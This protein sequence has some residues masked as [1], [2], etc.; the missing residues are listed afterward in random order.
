MLLVVTLRFLGG[1]LLIF[2]TNS[3]GASP[4]V[5]S[6]RMLLTVPTVTPDRFTGAPSFSPAEFSKYDRRVRCP[7]QN[8][9][10]LPDMRKMS[11]V[12]AARATITRTPTFSCDHRSSC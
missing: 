5:E 12:S 4:R 2:M 10:R 6:I 7:D 8:P 1:D 11:A 3:T 9:P